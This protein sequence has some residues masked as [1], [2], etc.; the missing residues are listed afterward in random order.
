MHEKRQFSRTPQPDHIVFLQCC[1]APTSNTTLQ[2]QHLLLKRA[3]YDWRSFKLKSFRAKKT[4][5]IVRQLIR[6]SRHSLNHHARLVFPPPPHCFGFS[7]RYRS[8]GPGQMLAQT[9]CHPLNNPIKQSS[10]DC[11]FTDSDNIVHLAV[12]S[13]VQEINSWSLIS[14]GSFSNFVFR[15]ILFPFQ[16]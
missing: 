7:S 6:L 16:K 1:S 2:A 3:L 13:E 4:V 15:M 10:E 12:P 11:C 14:R 8:P 9:S 5:P